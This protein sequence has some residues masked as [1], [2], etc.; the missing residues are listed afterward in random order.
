M[1]HKI[2]LNVIAA[3]EFGLTMTKFMQACD[4]FEKSN[5]CAVAY[6]TSID[7]KDGYK[8][9]KLTENVKTGYEKSGCKVYFIAIDTINGKRPKNVYAI[10]DKEVNQISDGKHSY[11]LCDYVEK[12]GYKVE[13]NQNVTLK[14]VI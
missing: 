13:V 7:A 11:R 6:K 1:T 12:C 4:C 8:K 3:N 10:F 2:V 9:T 14:K 5:V